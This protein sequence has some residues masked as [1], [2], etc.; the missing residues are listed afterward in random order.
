[1]TMHQPAGRQGGKANIDEEF[2]APLW[3]L[4]YCLETALPEVRK[5]P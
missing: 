3:G 2:A 4:F 5:K 1:M